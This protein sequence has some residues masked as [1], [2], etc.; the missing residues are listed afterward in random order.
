MLTDGLPEAEVGE[1]QPIG[2]VRLA[3]L[4]AA[5]TSLESLFSA[6]ERETEETRGDDWTAVILEVTP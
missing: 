5:H 3:Q 2:Y 6:I 4:A 1:E